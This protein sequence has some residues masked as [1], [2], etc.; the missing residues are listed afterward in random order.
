VTHVGEKG[1]VT[2]AD[3]RDRFDTSRKYALGFLEHLDRI[4]V[5]RRVGDARVLARESGA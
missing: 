2:V 3:L 1:Q 4:H 5:T